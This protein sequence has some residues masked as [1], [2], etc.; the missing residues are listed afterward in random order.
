M[1]L[2]TYWEDD[3]EEK[4]KM[5]R[6]EKLRAKK[7]G[8]EFIEESPE[9][10]LQQSPDLSTEKILEVLSQQ[11]ALSLDQSKKIDQLSQIILEQ[12]KMIDKISD[13]KTEVIIREVPAT[14]GTPTKK[15]EKEFKEK[16]FKKLDDIDVN[17]IDTSGIEAVGETIG[18]VTQGQNITS[19]VEKLRMLKKQKK[20]DKK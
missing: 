5:R 20:G 15:E 1:A 8:T 7:M 9:P 11:T 16:K 12:Q 2:I 6:E 18:T 14:G 10:I 17:M 19:Q 13:Q 3:S 4:R